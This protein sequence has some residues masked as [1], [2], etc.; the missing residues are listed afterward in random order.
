MGFQGTVDVRSV[1][2]A[3]VEEIEVTLMSSVILREFFSNLA[4]LPLKMYTWW[5]FCRPIPVF[6][7]SVCLNVTTFRPAK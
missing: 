3:A 5:V 4:G 6:L 2:I 7:N 1:A